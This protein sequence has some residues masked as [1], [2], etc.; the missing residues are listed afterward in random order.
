M[1]LFLDLA[2]KVH[3]LVCVPGHYNHMHMRAVPDVMRDVDLIV[4]LSPGEGR[5]D[6][7]IY[8]SVRNKGEAFSGP[9]ADLV[10]GA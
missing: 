6:D 10:A 7:Q 5:G 3:T 9:K 4:S 1:I 2:V 8:N